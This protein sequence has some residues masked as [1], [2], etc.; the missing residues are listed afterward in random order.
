MSHGMVIVQKMV[1]VA[2]LGVLAMPVLAGAPQKWQDLP[3]AV[4]DTVLANGGSEGPVDK[5]SELKGGKALYEAAVKDKDGNVKDLVIAEDGTLLETK[6]DDAA[7]LAAERAERGKKLLAG[8]K[9]THPT[10]ITNAYLPLSLLKQDI[11]E[12]TEEGKKVH[13]ERTARPDLHKTIKVAG[14]DVEAL[15][16]QDRATMDGQ[17]E[18]VATDY[19]A[20]DDNGTVYYLGEEVDEYKD[21]KV[22]SHEGSWMTGKDTEVP[23]VLMPAAPKIGDKFRSEDVSQTIGEIDEIVALAETVTVPAGTFK[24][25]LKMKETLA[26]GKIEIKY[27]AKGIGAIR[28]VPSDGDEQ[29][30]S[31]MAVE[32]AAP[33]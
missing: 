19:F 16:V 14:Q 20:Q 18:E 33:K 6:T 28:E 31:H 2:A 32:P 26:D 21:G 9:F 7:D 4:R 12:G 29:L 13:V 22:V 30:K 17:L 3:K 11:L 27:Y 5:E 24:D 15:V 8:V 1:L 10:Q 25:C 23:G